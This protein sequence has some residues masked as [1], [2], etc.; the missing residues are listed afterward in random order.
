MLG[1]LVDWFHRVMRKDAEWGYIRYDMKFDPSFMMKVK[2][3]EFICPNE[4]V[5]NL[6]TERVEREYVTD[7]V[8]AGVPTLEDLGVNLT[9]LEDV[10]EW[11]LKPFR[12]Y[13][14]YDAEL[15]EFEKAAPPPF[16]Q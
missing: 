12:A 11:E 14:Y 7:V 16:I 15:G 1:E 9:L 6:H 5:A 2:L 13:N 3:T 10:I 4:I 8:E